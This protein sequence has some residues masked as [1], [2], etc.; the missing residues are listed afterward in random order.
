MDFED[1]E[2]YIFTYVCFEKTSKL[3]CAISIRKYLTSLLF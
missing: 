1:I 3:I 2:L